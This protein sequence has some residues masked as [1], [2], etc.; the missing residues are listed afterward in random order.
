MAELGF[1]S[2]RI[3]YAAVTEYIATGEP[4][5]SRKL[6][7]RY[8]LDVS[9][10]TIR[11]ELADLEE[12]GFLTQPHT[13]A[14]RVP[15]DKG[16]R[17]FVDALGRVREAE[18]RDRSMMFARLSQ[19]TPGIDDLP[20]EAGRLLSRLTGSASVLHA[21]RAS[22]Q[23]V[24]QL[25]WIRLRPKQLLAVVVTR[26]GTVENRVVTVENEP[27]ASELERL[28]NYLDSLLGERTLGELRDLVAQAAE[29]QRSEFTQRAQQV[30]EAT[31]VAQAAS[32]AV[33]IEG[34]QLLLGQPDF[35]SVEKMRGV[36]GALAEHE[37]L[38][39]LLERT[40]A[41][42]GVQVLIGAETQLPDTQDLSLIT[43][44]FG[45]R[46]NGTGGLGTLGVIAPTR[47]DYQKVVPLVGFA[48]SL[49]TE[50]LEHRK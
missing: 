14:G 33:L 31:F 32:S 4:V 43:A 46:S 5:G 24:A 47:T 6:A 20:R 18:P 13:S 40:M 45:Q 25:K 9:P 44:S 7:R 8:G 28:H 30:V 29:S 36:L 15:T 50:L 35:A 19:L 2:R 10:A 37:R 22:E 3:L 42:G 21:T 41:A 49:L 17:A 38:L 26:A 27:D 16:F 12:S 23:Y 34:Q 1:R 48:A 39:E 11:N